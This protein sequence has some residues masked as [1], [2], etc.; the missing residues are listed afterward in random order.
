MNNLISDS[1]LNP[2][3]NIGSDINIQPYP[4]IDGIRFMDFINYMR[5]NEGYKLKKE[6]E[7]EN[8][9]TLYDNNEEIL[10]SYD[11]E[12]DY[13]ICVGE[14]LEHYSIMYDRKRKLKKLDFLYK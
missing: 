12:D 3:R 4:I 9:Y 5:K 11:N 6:K 7:N 13:I 10:L 2:L 14:K 8:Q 1:N